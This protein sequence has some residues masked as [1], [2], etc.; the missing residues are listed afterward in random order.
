LEK[1]EELPKGWIET[2]QHFTI[3]EKKEKTTD[4]SSKGMEQDSSQNKNQ[5]RACN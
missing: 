2:N 4:Y 3:Q 1:N 5:S